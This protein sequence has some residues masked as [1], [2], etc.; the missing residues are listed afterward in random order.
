MH[1]R[2]NLVLENHAVVITIIIII[3][4]IVVAFAATAANE[5]KS[6][7]VTVAQTIIFAGRKVMWKFVYI[8]KRNREVDVMQ[9]QRKIQRAKR[10]ALAANT[11][12]E[13]IDG[14]VIT[15]DQRKNQK[16]SPA[17]NL[18]ERIKP[19]QP[20]QPHKSAKTN[21]CHFF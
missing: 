4:G 15:I 11:A 5:L 12:I 7:S 21:V 19:Q 6:C 8:I 1:R 9:R 14:N 10:R 16:Q 3:I 17:K 18:K 13:I 2:E 20:Q